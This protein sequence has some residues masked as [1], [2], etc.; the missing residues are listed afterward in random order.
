[1]ECG[2]EISKNNKFCSKSCAATF[3][4]RIRQQIG[5]KHSSVTKLN[6]S[7]KIKSLSIKPPGKLVVPN[8]SKN[9]VE[10]GTTFQVS[11]KS[12]KKYCS[13]SCSLKNAGGYRDGSGKSKTGYYKGI[14]CGSTYELCWVIYQLDHNIP[15]VRFPG[16]LEHDGIRYYPDFLLD[17]N[18]TIIEI[19][20]Y[21][22]QY[23]VDLK[24]AVAE[25]FGYVVKVLRGDDLQS[26]FEYVKSTYH[27]NKY[28]T[29]YDDYT[30]KY[31]YTCSNC[32]ILFTR[33]TK[34][35]TENVFCSRTC[36]GKRNTRKYK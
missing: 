35:N 3:N 13:R 29:L 19:K 34:S 8:I 12:K 5:W 23:T 9:C 17:D 33:D 7:N 20:G 11:C 32:G 21:E 4:N 2:L 1:M 14:Y 24:T 36:N 30:P 26:V 28:Y 22:A 25:Y 6:I 31:E 10:C 18:I 15:F 27:T 16:R